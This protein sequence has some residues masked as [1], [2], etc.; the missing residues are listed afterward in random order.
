MGGP[1]GPSPVR[2]RV[3]SGHASPWRRGRIPIAG[4]A[5]RGSPTAITSRVIRVVG[6]ARDGA[7]ADGRGRENPL[8]AVRAAGYEPEARS[9]GAPRRVARPGTTRRL[10]PLVAVILT[11]YPDGM[12]LAARRS[13]MPT[14]SRRLTPAIVHVMNSTAIDGDRKPGYVDIHSHVLYGLDV[15]RRRAQF[16]ASVQ[17]GDDPVEPAR[18]APRNGAWKNA[19]SSLTCRCPRRFS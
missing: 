19:P 12:S 9:S 15:G 5:R 10:P 6:N 18:A 11:H 16:R 1:S 14:L 8:I 13:V 7:D 4:T 17:S 2:L 3:V